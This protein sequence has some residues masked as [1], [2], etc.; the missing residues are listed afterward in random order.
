MHRST[1]LSLCLLS[2]AA[3]SGDDGDKK[4]GGEGDSDPDSGAVVRDCGS[5]EGELP[6]GLVTLEH[7][8]GSG[9][10]TLVGQGWQVA[11]H[12]LDDEPLHEAVRFELAHPAKIHGFAVQYG[13]LPAEAEAVSASLFGD[14]GYNGFDFWHF[15]PVWS[16]ARCTEDLVEGEWAEF[17]LD[18]PVTI[19][20]P[21]LI[22]VGHRREQSA[23]AAWL[24]DGTVRDDGDCAEFDECFSALNMPELLQF[25]SGSATYTFWPGYSFP[26]QYDYMVRLYVEYTDDVQPE[27]AMLQAIPELSPSSRQSWGDVDNDGYD[28]LFTNGPRLYHNNG[29][30]SFTDITDASGLS[31]MG[32]SGS[33]GVWGDY[34]NDGCLD[35]FVFVESGTAGDALLRGSCDGSFVDVTAEAGILDVQDANPCGDRGYTTSPT[36]GAAWLDADSDGHLDLYLSNFICWD[37]YTFFTDTVFY[38]NGDGTF[39]EVTGENGFSS[40]ALAGR[41][42]NPIDHDQDGDVDILVNNYVLHRNLFFDNLGDGTFDESAIS[43]GLGGEGTLSGISSYYGHTIGTAWG[44]LDNDGDFDVV[45]ANLAHPRFYDF[46]NKT[47]VL[48]NDGTGVYTDSQGDWAR[49]EGAAGLRY[50]E[51]HSVPVLGDFDNDG[52]LD[53]AI[54][55]VYNGRPSDFYW[56]VGDGTFVLDNYTVGL[57][58]TNGW[59]MAAADLDNDGDLDLAASGAVYENTGAHSGHWLQVRPVGNVASNRAAIGATIRL[60]LSGGAVR[61]R[62]INGGTGQGNQDSLTAH[63]G[64]GDVTQVERVEVDFPGGG[65][66]SYDGPFDADQ[67]LWLMEDGATAAGWTLSAE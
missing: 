46:S 60:F 32:I 16:G 44:D 62:H 8:D 42:A 58:R 15:D 14:F 4:S 9:Q 55:A 24:F 2:L 19:D 37:N 40:S 67:R 39:R 12:P 49:P 38:S 63:F 3:C 35:L 61:V 48:I 7:H 17:V 47:Q 57:T 50:Q 66:V 33:G 23:D 64:L 54:S 56:G 25:T 51:T 36:P 34:D 26:F 28:D 31:A 41:G 10:T 18:E 13:Q 59:G 6:G 11:G 43:H 1:L 65:T 22:Y 30:G 45:Q 21:G 27:E 52:A 53:L 5:A 20:H 29:D